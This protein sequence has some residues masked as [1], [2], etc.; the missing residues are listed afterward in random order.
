MDGTGQRPAADAPHVVVIGAGIAGLAAA[1]RLATAGYRVTVFERHPH[2]GGKIRTTPS[3]AG[4]VAAGPTVLTMRHVFDDLFAQ[5]GS[6]LEDHLDLIPLDTI[7]RHVWPDGSQLDLF[8]DPDASA[9]AI[10]AFAG[11]QAEQEF[12]TFSTR[13]R[14]LFSAFDGPMMQEPHPN[15]A[16]LTAHV[17]RNPSL[18]QS[19]APLSSLKTLLKNSFTDPRLRQLF[20][21]YATYVGGAPKHAPA[22]LSLIWQ[23]EEAGVWAVEGGMHKLASAIAALAQVHG[24]DIECDT[25]VS[26]IN[27]ENGMTTG[28]TLEDDR[29]IACDLVLFAG[30]PRALTTGAFGSDVSK[31][32]TFKTPKARSFSARVHSFAA[33][34]IG[35][36][37]AHHTILFDADPDAEFNDLMNGRVPPDPSLY[38]C[39]MDRD[40]GHPPPT[41]ERFEIITNAPATGPG[42]TIG[43]LTQWHEMIIQKMARFGITFTPTPTPQTVTTELQFATMFPESMGAL[44]GQ[45]PHGLTAGLKRPTARS[46]LKGLYLAGGGCHPGAGVPM[47]TLSARHAVE[48]ILKDHISAFKSRP[49]AMRGGMLTE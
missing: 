15:L 9:A 32:I 33:T 14:T 13:A 42:S 11:P 29:T 17:L 18:I 5:A 6:R 45:S 46:G 30:D 16:A 48:A 25:H 2:L 47:A 35:L 4:P 21:R 23:A 22:I 38:I 36:D 20:G 43:D 12:R 24:T 39:A 27:V 8:H 26:R 28:V 37:L 34:P 44:Y 31:R 3:V 1:V 19:M 7:A 10:H 41:I 49:M 40:L